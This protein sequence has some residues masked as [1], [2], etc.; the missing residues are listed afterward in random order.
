MSSVSDLRTTAL[1]RV[2]GVKVV[3]S[4][5]VFVLAGSHS[6]KLFRCRASRT[7]AEMTACR[8]T[9]RCGS[10]RLA[11]ANQPEAEL[12]RGSEN[13][14]TLWTNRDFTVSQAPQPPLA[15]R[16]LEKAVP[17]LRLGREGG[18]IQKSRLSRLSCGDRFSPP[19]IRKKGNPST[20]TPLCCH[21]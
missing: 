8:P 4:L 6:T 13:Q 14:R 16:L 12:H 1:N 17:N 2:R 7:L 3:G 19:A 18:A 10:A 9:R 11:L 15:A 5:P 20:A 21:F